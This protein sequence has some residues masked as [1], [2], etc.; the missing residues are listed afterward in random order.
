[1]IS[2]IDF[3]FALIWYA[4]LFVI[5]LPG[6]LLVAPHTKT[7]PDRGYVLGKAAGFIGMSFVT[8]T[9]SVTRL[10]PFSQYSLWI[11]TLLLWGVVLL[12]RHEVYAL[13]QMH[14]NRII[15]TEII[16][17]LLFACGVALRASKPQ[18]EGIEKFMDSALLNGLMRTEVGPPLDPWYAGKSVNYYYFG[19][20][21]VALL[22]KMTGT[23]GWIAFNLGF[24]TVVSVAGGLLYSLGLTITKRIEGGLLVVF[25]ALFASNL[26]PF[27]A[28]MGGTTNYAFFSSGRYITERIN[29]YPFYSLSLG[30]LHAHMLGLILTTCLAMLMTLHIMNTDRIRSSAAMMGI[31]LGLMAATNAFDTLTC[32]LLAGM[33]LLSRWYRTV[34]RQLTDLLDAGLYCVAGASVPIALFLLHF[35]APTG[36]PGLALFEIPLLHIV[37]QFGI[38]LGLL[39]ASLVVL[40]TS[41]LTPPLLRIG[42]FIGSAQPEHLAL[43]IFSVVALILIVIPE[44]VFL[45]DVY[46]Y[47]NPPFKLANTVFKVWYTAWIILAIACGS[48]VTLAIVQLHRRQKAA[49]AVGWALVMTCITVISVGTIRGLET[50]RDGE[51]ASLNG[52]ALLSKTDPDRA[53][54][55]QWATRNISGQPVVLEASGESY[56]SYNWFSSLTGLPTIM[57]WRSHELGWRYSDSAWTDIV[58]RENVVRQIYAATSATDLRELASRETISYVMVGPQERDLYGANPEIFGAAFGTPEFE[59][60]TIDIFATGY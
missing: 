27:I 50:L 57:G 19:Q 7:L 29:E 15:V 31:L 21:M 53:A 34:D 40:R 14:R 60:T 26:H 22:A 28:L 38:P 3:H 37:W 49:A 32:S 9:L 56:S 1:M 4:V 11:F 41:T 5:G 30:D 42:Q 6:W 8:W 58:A 16:C 33:G 59:S 52:I 2:I 39:A 51:P 46:F 12:R 20:W 35:V 10:L 55:V 48:A 13:L 47:L 17:L 54:A 43:A 36:G 24:A 25:L 23:P 18:I 44:F 45:K